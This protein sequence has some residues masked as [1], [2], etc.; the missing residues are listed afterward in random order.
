MSKRLLKEKPFLELL[1]TTDKSQAK[2]LME[3]ITLNQVEVIVEILT[4]LQRLN[5]PQKTRALLQ[6]RKRVLTS[7]TNTR[8]KLSTKLRIIRRH[9]RQVIDTLH[10]VKR[11]LLELLK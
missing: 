6:K 11:R 9:F 1:L 3:T 4:N 7:L 2:A 5:V 10:S 8:T